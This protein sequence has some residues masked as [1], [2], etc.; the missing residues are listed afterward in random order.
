[1]INSFWNFNQASHFFAM[2][3]L[4]TVGFTRANAQSIAQFR[5]INRD[6]QYNETKLLNQWPESGPEMLW[7]TEGV[8]RGYAAPSVTKDK[9]FINGEIDSISHLFAFDLKGNLLWKTANGKEFFGKGYSSQF[10]GARSTPTV[11]DN[12]VYSCSGRGRIICC[13]A[14]SGTVKWAIDMIKDL[15]GYEPEFGIAES[16]LTDAENV[17]CYPGGTTNNIAALNRFTGKTVWTSEAVKDTSSFCSPIFITLP[18]RK[19]LVT[20]S[21][22]YIFGLDCKNGDLLWKYHLEGFEAEGDHC[23]TPVYYDGSIYHVTGD[24]LGKGTLKLELSKDG[25]SIREVWVNPQIKNI[26]GGF[27]ITD[28]HLFTTVKGNY[29]KKLELTDG[30][31][32]DSV[33]TSTGGLIYGDRKFICYGNNGELTLINYEKDK[34]EIGGKIKIEKGNFQHFSH[35]VLADGILYIRHGNALIAYKLITK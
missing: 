1:M 6:G 17:Y 15:G 3:I 30:V 14:S 35:P 26:F 25:T 13:N 2:V 23:N 19:I 4:V 9:L 22:H 34:F 18:A 33:K 8:G 12:L 10:P 29:L 27:V 16:L 32:S 7:A 31:V 24:R 21:H 5:G 28:N 11:V 20:F